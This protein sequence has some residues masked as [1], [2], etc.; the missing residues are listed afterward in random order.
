M[1]LKNMAVNNGSSQNDRLSQKLVA[2]YIAVEERSIEQLLKFI[3]AYSA[4]LIYYNNNNVASGTWA[5]FFN[6]QDFN[7]QEL[8][9]YLKNPADFQQYPQKLARYSQP[10]ISLILTFLQLLQYPQQQFKDLTQRHLDFYYQNVLSLQPKAPVADQVNVIFTLEN[11]VDFYQINKGTLLAAGQDD[12]GNDLFYGLDEDLLVSQTQLARVNTL[13]VKKFTSEE[14]IKKITGI[15]PLTVYDTEEKVLFNDNGFET[16]GDVSL[17]KPDELTHLW[18]QYPIH[19]G[20]IL[21]SPILSLESG[22]RQI[23]LTLTCLYAN[24]DDA[25]VTP[26]SPF[27]PDLLGKFTE[28]FTIEVSGTEE[29][30]TP[31]VS[32]THAVELTV[33]DNGYV[34]GTLE[35]NLTLSASEAAVAVPSA[36]LAPEL[37]VN[38][39]VIRFLLKPLERNDEGDTNYQLL[40]NLWLEKVDI[41]VEV[42]AL[43]NLNLRNDNNALDAKNPFQPFGAAPI[44]GNSFYFA[45]GEL[46]SKKLDELSVTIEWMDL[47]NDFKTHYQAYSDT[48]VFEEKYKDYPDL[49]AQGITNDSFNASLRLYDN[50]RWY[51]LGEA[52]QL[53]EQTTTNPSK[54][55]S[56]RNLTYAAIVEESYV[57]RLVDTSD[58]ELLNWSRYFRLELNNPDFM[59]SLYPLVVSENAN[60]TLQDQ[61][62]PVTVYPA[63]TP[64]I[65]SFRVGY[66]THTSI[67]LQTIAQQHEQHI[68][69]VTPTGVT[70]ITNVTVPDPNAAV[71]TNLYPLLPRYTEEASLLLGFSNLLPPQNLSLLFQMVPSSGNSMVAKPDISW[72]YLVNDSWKE[73][74]RGSLLLDTTNGLLDSGILRFAMPADAT[75]STKL[76]SGGLCWLKATINENSMAIGRTLD[77]RTQAVSATFVDQENSP[78]HL[79][80]PLAA[81]T[82]TDL[83][84]SNPLVKS[85]SQPYPSSK[86]RMAENN[87]NFAVRVSERLRHKQRGLT[88][89]DYE[90]LVLERFPEIYKVKCISKADQLG[91]YDP[92]KVVLIVIP[93]VANTNPAFAL[94][95]KAPLYLLEDIKNYLSN[96]LSP[97][98]KLEVK[99]P[100]YQQLSY[101]VGVKFYKEFEQGSYVNQLNDEL[102]QFLTPWA[103]GQQADI[104]F[105]NVL[106]SSSVVQFIEQRPYV[107][108]VAS[109][110]LTQYIPSSDGTGQL[111]PINSG[112]GL[113]QT[114]S[115]EAIL[116]SAATHMINML[117]NTG[118]GYVE[119]TTGIG[120]FK[121]GESFYIA[122]NI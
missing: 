115:P 4:K 100:I 101:R 61:T 18:P 28:F 11:N 23:N 94:Q 85:V 9:A 65:K 14:G 19:M 112:T 27:G 57:A 39:P 67:N 12:L 114:L 107:E 54:L 17:D 15:V 42:Q 78:N 35:F 46:C 82:I 116:V 106:H 32:P 3:Q 63:Y 88:G 109:L 21:S 7:I 8:V 91:A 81:D 97:F 89:W 92:A 33:G 93:N 75:P 66:K 108:Y 51:E 22:E 77:I 73:L 41:A 24:V 119:A 45:N 52:Q 84:R 31:N 2:D 80:K 76:F 90:R 71:V 117:S 38:Y 113:A 49:I 53:F 79:S 121:I 118:Q 105:G 43:S 103:Y 83:V 95:P 70:D 72:S 99:N 87:S 122:P 120:Y 10:H 86:G 5:A 16:F 55:S 50:H 6:Q 59:H 36:E 74:D 69:Q 30:L 40:K 26:I 64:Q 62:P 102:V 25:V 13:A 68:I 47:P 98:V 48:L 111:Q 37:S 56:I 104:D 60:N 58:D 1:N 44:T 20:L 110:S 29:W 34:R 96:F